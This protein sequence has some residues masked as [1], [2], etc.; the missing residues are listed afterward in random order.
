MELK[1]IVGDGM[2]TFAII[3]DANIRRRYRVRRTTGAVQVFSDMP[4]RAGARWRRPTKATRDWVSRA[5]AQRKGREQGECV[6]DITPFRDDDL[7]HE[8]L[9]ET[10]VRH[11]GHGDLYL[12]SVLFVFVVLWGLNVAVHNPTPECAAVPDNAERLACYDKFATRTT[13]EPAKGAIA[14]FGWYEKRRNSP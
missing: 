12:L 7:P 3:A 10:E 6:M 1:S 5:I 9:D 11:G 4:G 13:A 8:Q 2:Y 14:P